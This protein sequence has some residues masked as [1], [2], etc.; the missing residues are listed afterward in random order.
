MALCLALCC[1]PDVAWSQDYGRGYDDEP[2]VSEDFDHFEMTMGFLAGQRDYR[3]TPFQ[4]EGGSLEGASQIVGF[5]TQPPFDATE[6]YGLRYEMRAVIS[7]LRMTVGLDVPF[8]SYNPS[9]ASGSYEVDGEPQRVT[10]QSVDTL[11][12][13]FGLGAELPLQRVVPFFDVLGSVHWVDAR[14]AVGDEV[15]DYSAS[16]FVFTLRSGV[17]IYARDWF[18]A[19]IAGEYGL[20]GDT[21][22][23]A[24]LSLGFAIY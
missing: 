9:E 6:A 5:L 2:L 23:G 1:A 19:S 20:V 17:R 14:V 22:W 10:V 12:L 24:D 16:T 3:K 13:R 21:I 7:Y 11:D 15:V 8:L 4:L 18:F